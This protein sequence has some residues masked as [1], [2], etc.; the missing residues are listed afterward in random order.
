M[1]IVLMRGGMD[2]G[3]E[4]VVER[5]YVLVHVKIINRLQIHRLVLFSYHHA[6]SVSEN[7]RCNMKGMNNLWQAFSTDRNTTGA[8]TCIFI[9]AV[10]TAVT[11]KRKISYREILLQMHESLKREED[12]SGGCTRAGLRRVFTRKILQV[13]PTSLQES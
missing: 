9:K 4:R 11:N 6:L 10:K 12:H 13:L 5:P 1:I 7:T 3:R 8:M 2:F